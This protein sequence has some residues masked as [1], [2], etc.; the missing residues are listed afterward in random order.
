[1]AL[2]CAKPQRTS[3]DCTKV[4]GTLLHC[5]GPQQTNFYCTKVVGI[6]DCTKHQR[7]KSDCMAPEPDPRPGPPPPLAAAPPWF[8]LGGQLQRPPRPKCAPKMSGPRCYSRARAA[9]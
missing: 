6:A 7:S 4:A 9:C 1:M 8:V 5:T 3:F 2:D